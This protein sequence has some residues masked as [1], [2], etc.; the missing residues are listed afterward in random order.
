MADA[1]HKDVV[2]Y[3]ISPSIVDHD[4]GLFLE[5]RLQSIG[6]ERCLRTGWSG[7]EIIVQ[8]VQ[9]ASGLSIWAATA[10]QF[11]QNGVI[12]SAGRHL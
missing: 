9:S 4:V 2:L 7:A 11:I 3:N 1:E 10:C 12:K 8:L 6:R 5:D